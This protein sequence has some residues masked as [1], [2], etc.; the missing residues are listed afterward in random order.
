[1]EAKQLPISEA[2]IIQPLNEVLANITPNPPNVGSIPKEASSSLRKSLDDLFPEQKVE[3]KRL[4]RA[5][6]ILGDIANELTPAQLK[7]AVTE[8]QYLVDTWLDDFERQIFDGKTLKELLHE[9]G[10]L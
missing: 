8:V 9:N 4:Q 6:E 5:K 7:D 10:G 1:M 3:E 2:Q